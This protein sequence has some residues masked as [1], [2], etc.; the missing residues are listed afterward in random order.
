VRSKSE[1]IIANILHE[2]Q[3]PF[4][5][6]RPLFAPDG[7][8]RL[9]DF[10]IEWRG[11]TYYWEHLGML[12]RDDYEQD[13]EIKKVWYERFFPGSLLT[14]KESAALSRESEQLVTHHFC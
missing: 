11:Q 5:Y 3:I 4:T 9:P 7:S 6:E 10:T 14:T 1:V 2:R 8:W 13:W 12:D